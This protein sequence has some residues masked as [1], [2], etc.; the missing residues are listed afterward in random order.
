[1][2]NYVPFVFF[3]DPHATNKWP[4]SRTD[5][6]LSTILSKISWLVRLANSL[7]AYVL[8]GGDWVHRFNDRSTVI[9]SMMNI[10]RLSNKG[11]FG[12]VG[13]HDIYG[14]NYEVINDVITG[15]LFASGLVTLLNEVPLL[16]KE[17][18]ITVQLT[19]T[20]YKPDIDRDKSSYTIKKHPEADQAIHLTH[21][22]LLANPW[23]NI[24]ADKFT[25]IDDVQTEADV[26]C[27]GHDHRGFGIQQRNAT[28]FTN[29]GSLGRISSD[30][31]ELKRMPKASL[32]RVFKDHC[33]VTLIEVPASLGNKVLDRKVLEE[34]TERRKNLR[35]FKANLD[36]DF[37]DMSVVSNI[38]EIFNVQVLLQKIEKPVLE[39]SLEAIKTYEESI[40][41]A[42]SKKRG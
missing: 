23:P 20:N 30:L 33:E 3:T 10:L 14:H 6:F 38:D 9:N 41:N 4:S 19:G 42:T 35:D 7:D 29:P 5:N 26:I 11:V 31:V 21:S 40:V 16:V 15:A 17:N 22:F 24:A 36:L 13:N 12:I 32:I 28:V 1:M 8:V 2:D 27:I 25:V 37:G 34:E 39:T 18:G